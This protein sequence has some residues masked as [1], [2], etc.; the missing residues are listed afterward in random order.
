M[1]LEQSGRTPVVACNVG[2]IPEFVPEP[3]FYQAIPLQEK[4]LRARAK[5]IAAS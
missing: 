2:G 3:Q 4:S 1:S 5:R